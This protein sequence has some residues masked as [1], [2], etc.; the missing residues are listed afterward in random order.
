MRMLGYAIVYTAT[1]SEKSVN[2]LV[3]GMGDGDVIS[4]Q[5]RGAFCPARGARGARKWGRMGAARKTRWK[6]QRREKEV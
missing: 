2:T 5:D 6:G 3:G 1:R 4:A